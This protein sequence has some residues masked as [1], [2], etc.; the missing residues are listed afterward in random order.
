MKRYISYITIFLAAAMLST[1]CAG[2][3]NV[4]SEDRILEE[5]LFSD[6]DGFYTALNGVYIDL[7]NTNLY[8]GKLG[9]STPDILAQYY[10]T[11]VD[12]HTYGSL[13]QYQTEA[14]RTA[15]ADIWTRAY[16]LILNINKIIE[17]C[18]EKKGT[19]LN[20]T[21][22]NIIKGECLGLRALLHFEL[23]RYFGDIYS[24]RPGTD[25][26]PYVTSGDPKVNPILKTA[27]IASRLNEDLEDAMELLIQSDPVIETGKNEVDNGGRNLYNFRNLRFNYFAVKALAARIDMYLGSTYTEKALQ[28]AEEVIRDA[29]EFFPFTK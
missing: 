25:A 9:P 29:A 2:W 15:V 24:R 3:L 28:Y 6:R 22:Y 12:S 7:V 27:E 18:D 14:K 23:F 21:D 26:I 20:D 19:V 13:A 8:S 11:T 10:D 16:F 17:H 5:K 4:D 1:S